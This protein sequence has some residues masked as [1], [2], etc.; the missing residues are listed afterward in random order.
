[1]SILSAER[2]RVNGGGE[3]P[4]MEPVEGRSRRTDR[5][6][7]TERA[8][9]DALMELILERGLD[10]V[11]VGAITARAGIDRSTFYLH[12]PSKQALLE[13]SQRQIIDELVEQGGPEASVRQRLLAAFRHM[14]TNSLAYRVLL[15][16]SDGETERRLQSYLAG[17]LAAAFARR[18]HA[19]GVRTAG[20]LPLEL[21]GEYVAGGLRSASRWWLAA[22]MPLEPERMTEM[23]LRLLP[24][25][26]AEAA[27]GG[28]GSASSSL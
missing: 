23:V 6:R 28:A 17:H 20:G 9:R 7:N 14:A 2:Q 19:D 3:G 4:K 5:S 18:T 12:F 25:G 24:A 21:F 10:Q 11:T 16:A 8:L 26:V 1:M 15:T 27:A 22:G 13:A